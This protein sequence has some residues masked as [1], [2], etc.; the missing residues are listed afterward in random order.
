MIHDLY[1]QLLGDRDAFTADIDAAVQLLSAQA[2][3]EIPHYV[4][5]DAEHRDYRITDHVPGVRVDLLFFRDESVPDAELCNLRIN[6]YRNAVLAEA[7]YNG[8]IQLAEHVL[9]E[10]DHNTPDEKLAEYEVQRRTVRQLGTSTRLI[11]P[12]PEHLRMRWV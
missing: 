11:F 5:T 3:V 2:G 1:F 7:L 8:V 9:A 4:E 10:V 12:L 6:G